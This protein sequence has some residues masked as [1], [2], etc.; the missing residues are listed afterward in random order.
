MMAVDVLSLVFCAER[1]VILQV[2][3]RLK[4]AFERDGH[5]GQHSGF[6]MLEDLLELHGNVED[7]WKD[8]RTDAAD[9]TGRSSVTLKH[10]EGGE[11][12]VLHTS[13]IHSTNHEILVLLY[14]LLLR[15][16]QQ[17][18]RTAILITHHGFSAY[19]E[20]IPTK[21]VHGSNAKSEAGDASTEKHFQK[22]SLGSICR[23]LSEICCSV[24]VKDLSQGSIDVDRRFPFL[25][26]VQYFPQICCII[27]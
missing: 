21:T 22:L 16:S 3:E 13:D 2:D 8:L 1:A 10:A 27:S 25:H 7:L 15:L 26:F 23:R 19:S 12:E 18:I 20:D 11:D 9:D 14:T 6:Q 17:G 24:E 5:S 4:M